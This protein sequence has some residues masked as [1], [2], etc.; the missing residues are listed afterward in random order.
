MTSY[1]TE[2][3]L[4]KNVSIAALESALAHLQEANRRMAAVAITA[5][6]VLGL[7]LGALLYFATNFEFTAESVSIDSHQGTANYIGNNGDINNGGD[8]GQESDN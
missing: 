2:N 7:V 8:Q 5:L 3:E 4:E 6:L 1:S